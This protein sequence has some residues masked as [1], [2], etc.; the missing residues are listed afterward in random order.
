MFCLN[1]VSIKLRHSWNNSTDLF[2]FF[3]KNGLAQTQNQTKCGIGD[4]KEIQLKFY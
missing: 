3:H 2:M 4:Q 1:I